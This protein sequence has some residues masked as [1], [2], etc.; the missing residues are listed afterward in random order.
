MYGYGRCEV[1]LIAIPG[2]ARSQYQ[3]LLWGQTNLDVEKTLVFLEQHTE[4]VGS[5]DAVSE[6]Q[7]NRTSELL[8]R[9]YKAAQT[10]LQNS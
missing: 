9:Q 10:L 3:Y 2:L 1:F 6:A 7:R 5:Y 8:D 4:L